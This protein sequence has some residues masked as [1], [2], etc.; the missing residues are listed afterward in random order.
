MG[1]PHDRHHRRRRTP[2]PPHPRSAALPGRPAG[3]IR[4]AVRDRSKLADFAERGVEVVEADYADRESL[5][6]ALTGAD[7]Y[8]LISSVGSNEQRLEQHL[9]AVAAAREAGVGHILYTSIPEAQ[10]NPI[11]FASVH[12]DTE[13]AIRDSGLPFTF[14]RNNWYFENTTASL[15]AALEHGAIIGSAGEGKIAYATRADYA[16]AAAAV[17]ASEG[18]EGKAYELTGDVAITQAELADEVSRQSGK[19]VRFQNLSEADYRQA[20]EGFG[21]PPFLADALAEADARIAEGALAPTSDTLAKLIGRPTT[22]P[23][24][25]VQQALAALG[26]SN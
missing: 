1:A 13:E 5:V 26:T 14:L 16:E 23:A 11:G 6:R 19:D 17:L 20:L 9:N 21:L 24:E 22:T 2:R 15:G 25:A 12:K 3:Q 8:L 18:H 7:K 10:T 4:A